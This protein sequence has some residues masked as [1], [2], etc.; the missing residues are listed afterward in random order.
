MLNLSYDSAGSMLVSNFIYI[1]NHKTNARRCTEHQ[2]TLLPKSARTTKV[3][4]RLS[5]ER[6][7][8]MLSCNFIFIKFHKTDALDICKTT[9]KN[10]PKKCPSWGRF[11]FRNL[12]NR[13]NTCILPGV[14]FAFG[15]A[16]SFSLFSFFSVFF[17]SVLRCRKLRHTRPSALRIGYPLCSVETSATEITEDSKSSGE[18]PC[19]FLGGRQPSSGKGSVL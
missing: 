12:G 9:I 18:A 6:A 5:F 17:V 13:K 3:L 16:I 11:F 19:I 15:F 4:L 14:C 2:S 1:S 10:D 7:G 8:H